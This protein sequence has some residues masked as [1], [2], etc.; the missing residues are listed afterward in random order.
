MP[1]SLI[2]RPSARPVAVTVLSLLMVML[3]G[4]VVQRLWADTGDHA[5]ALANQMEGVAYLRPLVTLVDA[6]ADAQAAA[7]RGAPVDAAAVRARVN[8]VD[9]VDRAN[10][11][12]LGARQRW[13]D[14]RARIEDVLNQPGTGPAAYRA[15]SDVQALAAD[16]IHRVGDTSELA[17]DPD[18]LDTYYLVDA[19]LLRLPQV[20]LSASRAGDLAALAGGRVPVGEDAARVAVARH[21]VAQL[22]ADVSTGLT[23]AIDA[24]GRSVLGANIAGPLDTFRAAVD[25]FAPPVVIGTLAEP[26]DAR[27]LGSAAARVRAAGLALTSVV[28]DELDA[29]IGDRSAELAGERRFVAGDA[30]AMLAA[31]LVLLWLIAT[32]PV[33]RR[34]RSTVDSQD[35]RMP[36]YVDAMEPRDVVDARDLSAFEE[37]VHV[38]RAVQVRRR[39]V[40][41]DAG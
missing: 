14:L 4:A 6:V 13:T 32:R 17:S 25:G 9:A 21:D 26:V 18:S 2:R 15:F 8:E 24:T 11:T 23:K 39:E 35:A 16:L 29:L 5:E 7:V 3:F 38:G 12:S 34:R 1:G 41:D 20:L 40:D 36:A 37:L 22:T 19:G 31:G 28:F 27:D 10:G 33:G 30:V